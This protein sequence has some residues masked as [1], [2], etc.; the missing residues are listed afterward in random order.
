MLA[1]GVGSDY[2]ERPLSVALISTEAKECSITTSG[3][4]EGIR[5]VE[6]GAGRDGA[7]GLWLASPPDHRS[8]G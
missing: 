7:P 4:S 5:A 1:S 6:K 8:T 3:V 2:E